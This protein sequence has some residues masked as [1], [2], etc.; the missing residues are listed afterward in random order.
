MT[1]SV[2]E[3]KVWG[4]AAILSLRF[5][6]SDYS[7]PHL[8]ATLTIRKITKATITKVINATRKSPILN[9]CEGIVAF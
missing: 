3:E 4:L 7:M 2:Q 6:R 1:K 5:G 9:V 8:F